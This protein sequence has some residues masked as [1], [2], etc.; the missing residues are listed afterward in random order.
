MKCTACQREIKE[1]INE[2]YLSELHKVNV[3]RRVH[4]IPPLHEPEENKENATNDGAKKKDRQS[5]IEIL[6]LNKSECVFC[7]YDGDDLDEHTETHGFSK[8]LGLCREIVLNN[9]C[10]YCFKQF[11]KRVDV[12]R[13]MKDMNHCRLKKEE[14]NNIVNNL[15]CDGPTLALTSGK[16]LGNREYLRYFRQYHRIVEYREKKS[17]IT[18]RKSVKEKE[19][20]NESRK[21]ELKVSLQA[22]YQKHFCEH[23]MQ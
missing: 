18:V 16:T 22:N 2:H 8:D 6:P 7:E 21:N 11:N 5:Y 15:C 9:L 1:G 3:K 20:I 19:K 10:V 17:E 14:C 12:K 4:S 23:W 13:H